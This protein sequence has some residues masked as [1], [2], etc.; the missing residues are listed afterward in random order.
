MTGIR[1][2]HYDQT[3]GILRRGKP[4]GLWMS[5]VDALPCVWMGI[6][7]DG[8]RADRI[9]GTFAEILTWLFIRARI[10]QPDEE[11]TVRTERAGIRAEDKGRV[12]ADGSLRGE[13]GSERHR[14]GL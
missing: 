2:I 9:L 8:E 4:A 7:A 6:D 1:E 12:H 10:L 5:K 3:G 14:C 13:A 11:P